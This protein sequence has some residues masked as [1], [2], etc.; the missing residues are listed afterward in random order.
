[1]LGKTVIKS[2]FQSMSILA[3]FSSLTFEEQTKIHALKGSLEKQS[4]RNSIQKN[5]Q[6]YVNKINKL[7]EFVNH[8]GSMAIFRPRKMG[9]S[10]MIEDIAFM[11]ERS[12]YLFDP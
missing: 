10:T 9:K 1:M 6:F 7:C 4:L 3:S 12:K 5:G 11:H 2:R 8:S